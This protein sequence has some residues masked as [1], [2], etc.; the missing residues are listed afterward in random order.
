MQ[1]MFRRAYEHPGASFVEVYQ[2]CNVFNDGA[3][4]KITKRDAREDM[5][6]N[7]RH[8]ERIEFGSEGQF[9]VVRHD[10]GV[11]IVKV[12]DVDVSA[13]LVHDEERTDP[14]TAF[15]LSRLAE[16]ADS[17]T[18]VGVFRAVGRGEYSSEVNA[19]LDEVCAAS[20]K[21]DLEALLHSLP[22]W[23]V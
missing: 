21:G 18:P 11:E 5:L 12:G 7:L 9:G 15:A 10:G 14:S 4:E 1:E 3:F 13:L 22:T 6:I 20:G 23:T 2:N 17:P 8:G 16:N 19:Q